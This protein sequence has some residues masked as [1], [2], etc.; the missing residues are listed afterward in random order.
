MFVH[1]VTYGQKGF[2]RVVVTGASDL[3]RPKGKGKPAQ[4][5]NPKCR[6]TVQR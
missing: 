1:L 4:C 3:K 2:V 5:D 6:Y